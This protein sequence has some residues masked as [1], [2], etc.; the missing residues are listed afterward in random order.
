MKK[1]ID[2]SDLEYNDCP[3][4]YKNIAD[5]TKAT[6]KKF[7]AM[8]IKASGFDINFEYSYDKVYVTRRVISGEDT[9]IM[10]LV[11]KWS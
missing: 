9:E 2:L 3:D 4:W 6:P 8:F 10:S 5:K 7:A 11:L 1:T